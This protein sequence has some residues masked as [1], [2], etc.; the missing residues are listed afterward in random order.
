MTK[1]IRFPAK[2]L[3][4]WLIGL[5]FGAACTAQEPGIQ[6][7]FCVNNQDGASELKHMLVEFSAANEFELSD[8]GA[9]LER[10]LSKLSDSKNAPSFGG[11]IFFSVSQNEQI[12]MS[13]SN[14]GLNH[15]QILLAVFDD[16]TPK[17]YRL[18]DGLNSKWTVTEIPAGGAAQRDP[19]CQ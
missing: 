6:V 9:K 13:A 2:R 4:M 16:P 8:H 12:L 1:R 11:R 18:V 10:D 19:E 3:V 5:T 14:V 7:E 17:Y 15:Y